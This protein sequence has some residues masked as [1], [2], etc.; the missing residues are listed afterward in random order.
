[1]LTTSSAL[2]VGQYVRVNLSASGTPESVR[3]GGALTVYTGAV[4][5]LNADEVTISV[6]GAPRAM[7]IDR[8][9]EVQAGK[10]VGGAEVI[11]L[12]GGYTE[13]RLLCGQPGRTAVPARL[14]AVPPGGRPDRRCGRRAANCAS[15]RFQRRDR[16]NTLCRP[17]PPV[18]IGGRRM[19]T[20]VWTAMSACG[21]R[22]TNDWYPCG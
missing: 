16:G 4:T 12:D 11:D 17:T 9:T 19:T 5:S 6:S 18:T 1:M 21:Y 2:K 3:V 8:F 13:G 10:S 14:S 15:D 7:T 20:D 22:R